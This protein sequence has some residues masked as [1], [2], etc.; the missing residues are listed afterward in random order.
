M[1]VAGRAD[2]DFVLE[3]ARVT[4]GPAVLF[5]QNTVVYA[6]R[7][8]EAAAHLRDREV[9]VE[10][11]LGTGGLPR[12]HHVDV[13]PQRGVRQHQRRLSNMTSSLAGRCFLSVLDFDPEDL[14][15]QPGAGRRRSSTTGP[16]EARPRRAPRSKGTFIALLFEKALVADTVDLRDR[17]P[18]A[19]G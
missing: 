1:A 5:E 7:E 12:R 15:T 2:V 16:P 17:D 10:V 14:Q 8:P 9:E 11:D 4:I 6:E 3:R 19:R 13:R 18:R